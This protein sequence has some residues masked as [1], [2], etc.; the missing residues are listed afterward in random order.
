M[1]PRSAL[2]ERQLNTVEAF[3]F[4]LFDFIFH[5]LASYKLPEGLCDAAKGKQADH[6][7]AGSLD[8]LIISTS[9]SFIIVNYIV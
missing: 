5:L 3:T 9:F 6:R 4:S 7:P 8:L 1:G 2:T